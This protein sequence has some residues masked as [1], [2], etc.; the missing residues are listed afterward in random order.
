MRNRPICFV[1]FSLFSAASAMRAQDAVRSTTNGQ[2]EAEAAPVIVSATRTEIPLDQSPSSVSV[3]DSPDIDRKQIERVSD[4]LRAVPGLSV[5]QTGTT[6]QLTSAVT[7][8][9]R[10][11]HTQLL[12]DDIPV[13]D[14]Y[15]RAL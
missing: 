2:D 10:R 12:L 4:A 6:G 13:N 3:I 14:A 15:Q 8:G 11:E 7:R 5:V 1:L 9:F